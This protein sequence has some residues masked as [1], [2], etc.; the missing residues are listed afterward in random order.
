MSV[1]GYKHHSTGVEIKAQPVEPILSLPPCGAEGLHSNLHL[2]SYLIGQLF[3][4]LKTFPFLPKDFFL[5]SSD[6]AI[7]SPT[8]ESINRSEDIHYLKRLCFNGDHISKLPVN[9][10]Y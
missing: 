5:P 9:P 1:W 10:N 6:S 8:L 7:E 4:K 2:L 3:L